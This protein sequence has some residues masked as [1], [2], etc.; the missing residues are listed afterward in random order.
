MGLFLESISPSSYI[1]LNTW[2]RNNFYYLVNS[3][4]ITSNCRPTPPSLLP[5]SLSPDDF[6]N[7]KVLLTHVRLPTWETHCNL[8]SVTFSLSGMSWSGRLLIYSFVY[9][10]RFTSGLSDIIISYLQWYN[11]Y[12]IYIITYN[13]IRYNYVTIKGPSRP[14]V[15]KSRVGSG[16]RYTVSII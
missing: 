2:F 1:S 9:C 7:S 3:P 11:N 14:I 8:L 12:I 16:C 4:W 5:T 15:V 10:F 13:C 6:G